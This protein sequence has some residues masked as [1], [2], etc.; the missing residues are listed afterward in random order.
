MA[1]VVPQQ[2]LPAA[3]AADAAV[4]PPAI[5]QNPTTYSARFASMGDLY[6]GAYLPLLEAHDPTA[7]LPPA[8]VMQTALNLAADSAL[9]GVYVYQ[10]PGTWEVRTVHRLSRTVTRPGRGTPWDGITFAFEG[11]VAP[12]GLIGLVQMPAHAFHLTTATYSPTAATM[13]DLLAALD[14]ATPCLG[15]FVVGDADVT[16]VVARRFTPVPY[17]YVQYLHNKVLTPRQAWQVAEQV[18][19]DGRAADCEIFVNFLRAACTY[20]MPAGAE[21]AMSAASALPAPLVVPL[22]DDGLRRQVGA[23][24][25]TDLPA[26][27]VPAPGSVEDQYVATTAV[28]RQE[29]ALARANAEAA[30]A[31]AKAPKSFTEA[32]PAQAL[33]LRRLC[34]VERHDLLPIFW[35]EH[36]ATGGKKAQSLSLLQQL[37]S[38][39]S[40]DPS[41]A[42][43]H[44]MVSVAL[45]ESVSQFHLGA[46]DTDDLEEGISPFLICPQYHHLA[47]GTRYECNNY[48]MLTSGSGAASMA[49]IQA[50]TASKLKAPRDAL[51][52]SSF[53][54]GYSCLLDVLLGEDHGAAARLRQHATFWQQNAQARPSMLGADQLP[55]FLMRIMRT[56]QLTT[57]DYIN[58]AL[59]YGAEAALPD[60]NPIQHTVRRRTWQ[61]LSHL[62]L[63]YLEE[64]AAALTKPAGTASSLAI[65]AGLSAKPAAAS[66][67][68]TAP[69]AAKAV[70][71]D[72]PKAHQNN[73]WVT[74][75]A[76]SSKDIRIHE[77][78][79]SCDD[80]VITGL[81]TSCFI[82]L[83]SIQYHFQ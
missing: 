78:F 72:A 56:I 71:V 60:Y 67:T 65:A 34:S 16:S 50:L 40:D 69:S 12:P 26:L 74:K 52:L 22:A 63:Q 1:Q 4:V 7:Q 24:M 11:D 68:V 73:D 29:F 32:F 3:F 8:T 57:I 61:N 49:D 79:Y 18:I 76:A 64:S 81:I 6:E 83:Y 10:A 25:M 48:G 38:N 9:P 77:F 36:A 55:G 21:V 44:I 47:A 15:P 53:V 19:A 39:R 14:P 37:V 62:P 66:T 30:R 80:L 51:E 46:P 58:D 42:R 17:A 31:E 35:I 2:G 45:F 41:S 33:R 59:K 20:R 28:V 5:Q 43:S 54:G 27:A 70:R 13:Q 75:Y 82:Y 23:W